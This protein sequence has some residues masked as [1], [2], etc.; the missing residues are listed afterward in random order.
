MSK[1]IVNASGV[2]Q[3]V[4]V[5]LKMANDGH[6]YIERMKSTGGASDKFPV[7]AEF[8][9]KVQKMSVEEAGVAME[10]FVGVV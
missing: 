7:S 3:D 4:F 2:S 6:Y 9:A 10:K 1:I 8:A 5:W